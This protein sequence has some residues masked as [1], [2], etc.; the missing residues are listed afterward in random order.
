MKNIGWMQVFSKRY[1]GVIYQNQVK[2]IIS[3]KFNLDLVNLESK[4]FEKFR[5]LRIPESFVYL[6][7]LKG[8]EDLW[9]RDFYSTITLNKKK[10]KGRNLALLFHIDFSGFPIISRLP[11]LFL[12]KA[13]LY[14]QLKRV[15]TIVT[16]SEYWKNYFLNRGYKNVHKIYCGFDLNNFDISD[17]DVAQFKKLYGLEKKPIIYLGNCQ[18]A[19]GVVDSYS[20]LKDLDVYFV[21]S[22]RQEVK[23]PALNFNLGYKEYLKLLKA[24]AIA[25][26]MSKFKEGWCIT[27]HEAML[28]KT[29]VVGSGKGGMKELLEGGGQIVCEDFNKLREIVEF[30]LKDPEKRQKMAERGNDYAKNFTQ[31]KFE[32][33]W[34]EALNKALE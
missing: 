15:E 16:I 22:G 5:Y 30:L 17:E 34:E 28:C 32:R 19:K 12:E 13:F 21:T 18:R 10:T 33:A 3:K 31:E 4:Y 24:S 29:P 26:T 2:D 11:F 9:I 20:A 27:A 25:L 23:I 7:K 6:L 8:K 1:G 14:R